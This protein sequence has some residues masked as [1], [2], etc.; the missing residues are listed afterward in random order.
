M[1]VLV[2]D[3]D[4]DSAEALAALLALAAPSLTVDVAFDG[5]KAVEVA[6]NTCPDVVILDLEMPRLNGFGAAATIKHALGRAPP[7]LIAVSGSPAYIQ[8][9]DA[10]SIFDHAFQKPLDFDALFRLVFEEGATDVDAQ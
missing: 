10:G 6:C 9:A 1:H 5:Q 4:Q 7:M 3:D 8:A 2:C